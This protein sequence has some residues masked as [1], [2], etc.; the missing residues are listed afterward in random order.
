MI[1]TASRM[2]LGAPIMVPVGVMEE[3]GRAHSSVIAVTPADVS[4]AP[5][6][7]PTSLRAA[8]LPESARGRESRNLFEHPLGF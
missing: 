4:Q 5:A 8:P 1:D 3:D 6:A 7:T 2:T